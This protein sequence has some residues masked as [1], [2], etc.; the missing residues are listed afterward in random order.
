MGLLQAI[1]GRHAGGGT[2]DSG[3]PPGRSAAFSTL[4]PLTIVLGISMIQ[5]AATDIK[6]HRSDD[7]TNNRLAKVTSWQSGVA[8][9]SETVCWRDIRVGNFLYISNKQ[10]LPADMVILASI[11]EENI[12]YIETS[13]IDGETNLKLRRAISYLPTDAPPMADPAEIIARLEADQ[14]TVKCE[15]PNGRVESFSGA[16]NI[17]QH[18]AQTAF[19]TATLQ[20]DEFDKVIP[21]KFENVL[22]RGAVLR[23]TAWAVRVVVYTGKD[24]KLQRNSRHA[25]SKISKIDAAVNKAI[26][27]VFLTDVVLVTISA[28]ILILQFEDAYFS[29]LTNLGYCVPGV[30]PEWA[31]TARPDGMQ[32]MAARSTFVQGFLTLIVLF[33]NFC[34]YQHGL[35]SDAQ[36]GS[37]ADDFLK[38]LALCHTVVIE[39]DVMSSE[40]NIEGSGA[41]V[42]YQAESP[43]EKAL[44][45]FAREA[46][47]ELLCRT[48]SRITI[49][50]NGSAQSWTVLAVNKFDSDRKRMSIV[51]RDGEGSMRLLCKGA[52]TA[53]LSR[54]SCGSVEEATKMVDHL[55]T[56]GQ[57]GL[58]TLVL[59]YRDLTVDQYAE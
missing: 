6:R 9:T 40:G 26:Y 23:N 24:I 54:G 16:F 11:E 55:K 35:N 15:L 38:V 45:E 1:I 57:E 14:P 33:N 36:P 17:P 39:S 49:E 31:M 22:L 20:T 59:G 28:L 37:Q 53:M 47:Y 7:E 46:G 5:E 32:W 48:T 4:F 8:V 51:V 13:S 21:V 44:V 56:F 25:P 18:E 3:R 27:M 42:I 41:A 58:R 43:D 30:T 29:G 50:I 2:H 10:P 52:D 34:P 12:C 19:D